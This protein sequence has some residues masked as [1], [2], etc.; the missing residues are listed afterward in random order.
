MVSLSAQQG[1]WVL[2]EC[3]EVSEQTWFPDPHISPKL[4]DVGKLYTLETPFVSPGLASSPSSA[5]H[6]YCGCSHVGPE[7]IGTRLQPL[8][9]RICLRCGPALG[10]CHLGILESWS[11]AWSRLET[12]IHLQRPGLVPPV[13]VSQGFLGKGL[14]LGVLAGPVSCSHEQGV[15][16]GEFSWDGCKESG[17]GCGV[18]PRLP[19][20]S[21]CSFLA[22]HRTALVSVFPVK[23][24]VMSLSLHVSDSQ[25]KIN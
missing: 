16:P 21:G 7:G 20:R 2:E 25:A 22:C 8:G 12:F 4:Q 10:S 23:L 1:I 24:T 14:C 9:P 13:P 11:G 5:P 19:A 3:F 6:P 18:V 15:C 17:R